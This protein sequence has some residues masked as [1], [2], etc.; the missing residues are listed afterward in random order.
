MS[1]YLVNLDY[2][3]FVG[4]SKIDFV[5]SSY[6]V[7]HELDDCIPFEGYIISYRWPN[8]ILISMSVDSITAQMRNEINMC[9]NTELERVQ[10]T[11]RQFTM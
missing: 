1:S 8:R 10:V 5:I 2:Y 4:F 6:E 9:S 3:H 7:G 11:S